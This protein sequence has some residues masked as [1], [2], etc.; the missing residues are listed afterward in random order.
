MN[1]VAATTDSKTIAMIELTLIQESPDNPRQTYDQNALQELAK[2]IASEG[3]QV[4]LLV[5]V[6]EGEARHE[7]IAG[8]RRIRAAKIAGLT[9]VPCVLRQYTDE[10]ARAA[11]IIENLLREGLTPLDEAEAYQQ[12]FAEQERR[13]VLLPLPTSQ[14][15]WARRRAM[16]GFVFAF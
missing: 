2:S 7:L 14:R 3:I 11:R 4:P 13:I 15:S 10:E 16:S 1:T 5:R 9:E 12:M 8:H 6:F